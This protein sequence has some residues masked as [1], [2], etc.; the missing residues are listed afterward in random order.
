[1]NSR[2]HDIDW[3]Q[4]LVTLDFKNDLRYG[5]NYILEIK[6]NFTTTGKWPGGLFFISVWSIAAVMRSDPCWMS[7]TL[8]D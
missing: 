1:M 3:I 7:Y 5:H 8:G 2:L 6:L 4:K